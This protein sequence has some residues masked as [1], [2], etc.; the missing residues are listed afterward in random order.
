[1]PPPK[2]FSRSKLSERMCYLL[3]QALLGAWRLSPLIQS[4]GACDF[5]AGP[6]HTNGELQRIATSEAFN[7]YVENGVKVELKDR[8]SHQQHLVAQRPALSRELKKVYKTLGCDG[9]AANRNEKT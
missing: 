6:P 3:L 4:N 5:I 9:L 2:G 1:M 7:A 8:C